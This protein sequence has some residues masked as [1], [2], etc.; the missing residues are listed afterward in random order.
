MVQ[1]GSLLALSA[2]LIQLCISAPV[3]RPEVTL[4]EHS[5]IK[6][7]ETGPEM[8]GANF[9]GTPHCAACHTWQRDVANIYDRSVDHPSRQ[10]LVR[11]RNKNPWNQPPHSNCFVSRLR[12]LEHRQ[13]LR[14]LPEGC[15]TGFACLGRHQLS[16]HLGA[17]S[18]STCR[19]LP[20]DDHAR[21]KC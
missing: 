20:Y 14:R 6:R 5:L 21:D 4:V 7:S 15:V 16:E 11:F 1:I 18:H 2:S 10:Y 17:R 8:G 13:K 19:S 9:P 12:Y 3:T